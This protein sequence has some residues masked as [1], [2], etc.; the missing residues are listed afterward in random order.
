LASNTQFLY[1]GES[2][3]FTNGY[4]L[5]QGDEIFLEISNAN[6]LFAKSGGSTGTVSQSLYFIA[7]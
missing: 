2:F 1:I 7:R 5:A 4:P 6:K 3:G